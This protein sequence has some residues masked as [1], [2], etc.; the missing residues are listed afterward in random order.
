MQRLAN[1]MAN[2]NDS[3]DYESRAY[4]DFYNSVLSNNNAAFCD[5]CVSQL[6]EQIGENI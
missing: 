1:L 5:H 2:E 6:L 3:V 4:D